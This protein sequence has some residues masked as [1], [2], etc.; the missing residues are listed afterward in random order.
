MR[1]SDGLV[2]QTWER[3]SQGAVVRGYPM[4][5]YWARS[6]YV[7]SIA[8]HKALE[9]QRLSTDGLQVPIRKP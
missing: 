9:R 5:S 2:N 7:E 6:R 8:V 4:V 3:E 1:L